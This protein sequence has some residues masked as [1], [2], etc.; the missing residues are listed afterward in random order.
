MSTDLFLR[1]AD[2][3]RYYER[4]HQT[5]RALD[6]VTISVARGE[7]LSIVGSSG[8]GKTTLLNLL[9]GLDT[10]TSGLVELNGIPLSTMTRRQL[11]AYRAHKVGM[12]FQSFNLISHYTALQN[13][14]TAL[15]FNGT[16]PKERR[17]LASEILDRLGLTD[18]LTHRPA[19]L[20]GG[21]QQRVAVA[22]AIVKNPEIL[23]ADE[24]TG[25]LDFD[26]AKQL[27]ELLA[28]LSK[29][30]LTIVL[31]THNL[32]MAEQ[33]SHRIVRMQYGHVVQNGRRHGE[34][35]P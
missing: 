10:P 23:F 17:R 4:G 22:R 8:S 31:V 15:Y 25:N 21:E 19:D 27:A 3:C 34:V 35:Q 18:R 5:V 2:L 33:Y 16:T 6:G 11:S 12:I 32:E 14:E 26:N 20:S 7:F 1:T 30:G 13:V 9:A 24:P 28:T 29:N